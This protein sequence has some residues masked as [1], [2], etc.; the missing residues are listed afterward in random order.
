MNPSRQFHSFLAPHLKAY[1]ELKQKL[2]YTS[3]VKRVRAKDLDY[4]LLFFGASSLQNIT[5]ATLAQW[6]HSAPKLSP[7]T[8]NGKLCFA[9]GFFNYL[10]RIGLAQDNPALRIPYLKA[11]SRPPYLYS[12]QDIHKILKATQYYRKRYPDRP[13]G[14]TLETMLFLIYACGLRLSEALNLKMKD[15][16][17]E[18][19]TLALWNT[20]FHKERL[21]PFSDAA[22]KKLRAYLGVHGRF[23]SPSQPDTPFFC[24]IGGEKYKGGLIEYHFRR[25]LRRCGI[26]PPKGRDAPRIHDLRHAFA[27][28]RL[29]KWYQEGADPLNK[30]PLLSTYMGHVNIENT[31]VYLTITQSLLREGDRRFQNTFEDLAHKSVKRVLRKLPKRRPAAHDI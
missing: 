6:I 14:W 24:Q 30:L 2:G 23:S 19:N 5:E 9:R 4:Y 7:R 25:I 29:Y 21:L 13:L 10:I 8:K 15:L 18:Q 16:D 26:G 22:A 28:H 17:F 20:K 11:K 31:Q 3:F 1:L 12:L 27:V